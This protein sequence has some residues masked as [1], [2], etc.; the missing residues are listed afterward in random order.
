MNSLNKILIKEILRLLF[1][2]SLVSYLILFILEF[3]QT[4]FVSLYFN[5]D[6]ILILMIFSGIIFMII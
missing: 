4:G 3:W 5:S 1:A 6:I 2:A